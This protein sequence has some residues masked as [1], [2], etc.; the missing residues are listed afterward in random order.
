MKKVKKKVKVIPPI[1]K[2]IDKPEAKSKSKVQARAKSKKEKENL[3]SG[4]VPFDSS[5]VLTFNLLWT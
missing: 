2:I 5:L 4:L 3:A 1:R